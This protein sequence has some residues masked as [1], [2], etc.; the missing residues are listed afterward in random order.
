MERK[1]DRWRVIDRGRFRRWRG[2]E[3]DGQ[4]KTQGAGVC[5][6]SRKLAIAHVKR[7]ECTYCLY[8]EIER[9]ETDPLLQ[10]L[11]ECL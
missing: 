9:S 3:K 8:N 4:I 7:R 10:R 5:Y 2:R 1:G 11:K 6:T